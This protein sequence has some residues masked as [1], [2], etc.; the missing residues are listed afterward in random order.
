MGGNSSLSM[1]QS[2]TVA[3][4]HYQQNG[5]VIIDDITLLDQIGFTDILADSDIQR[6]SAWQCQHDET[7]ER[8]SPQKNH[9][10]N[11]GESTYA[12]LNSQ[13]MRNWL[14]LVT[15][16]Q[17]QL[18]GQSSC[19]TYYDQKGDFLA[20]HT[21]HPTECRITFLL[22]LDVNCVDDDNPGS[23]IYLM[24]G[25]NNDGAAQWMLR[26]R[27]KRILVL[28]GSVIPH[29]RPELQVGERVSMISACFRS[30]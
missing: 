27:P 15:G 14:Y 17:L 4:L 5:L 16:E 24:A 21:D 1:N 2:E 29:W 12:W 10:A 11:F 7:S 22:Y 18:S 9:R 28:N 3:F 20:Q 13:Y 6:H 23:G 30:A 25:R 8:A 19:F 26:A